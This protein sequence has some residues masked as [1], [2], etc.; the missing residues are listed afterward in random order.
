MILQITREVNGQ[1]EEQLIDGVSD[2]V[3]AKDNLTY[4][5]KDKTFQKIIFDDSWKEE[6]RMM[7]IYLLNDEGKTIKRIYNK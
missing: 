5:E 6:N 3:T 7:N 4:I 2:V 1:E